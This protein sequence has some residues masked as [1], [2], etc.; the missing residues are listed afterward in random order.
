MKFLFLIILIF[1]FSAFSN[2][3]ETDSIPRKKIDITRIADAPKINGILDDKAWDGAAIA[4]GFVER[5]PNNG[6][7]IPDSL[8]TEVKIIY[9]DLGKSLSEYPRQRS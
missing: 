9:D 4:T 3:Q 6:K 1:F 5:Q 8:H 7:P 2:A